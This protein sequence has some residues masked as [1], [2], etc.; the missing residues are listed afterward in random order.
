MEVALDS[1][2]DYTAI[3]IIARWQEIVAAEPGKKKV[4]FM[5]TRPGGFAD[6]DQSNRNR[7][8]LDFWTAARTTSGK[9]AGSSEQAMEG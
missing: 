6:V 9:T 8:A 3:P 2:L 7:F 5:L 1:P 4:I